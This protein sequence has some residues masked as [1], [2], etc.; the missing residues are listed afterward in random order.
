MATAAQRI[1]GAVTLL[2]VAGVVLAPRMSNN[3]YHS[4]VVAGAL[5]VVILAWT[6]LTGFPVIGRFRGRRVPER[7]WDVAAAVLC[8]SGTGLAGLIAYEGAY[9]VTW[10][11]RM[12]ESSSAVPPADFTENEIQYFSHFPNML[13][14]LAIARTLRSWGS[15]VGVAD[16]DAMFGVLNS[17]GL[18]VTALALYLTIRMARGPAWG[19]LGLLLLFALLGT[20]PWLAVPYTDMLALWTPI[21]AVALF[22][23][24]LR[25]GRWR[26]L[27]L[28][29]AGGAV[30]GVGTTVKATP[31]VGLV[32][33]LLT[34]AVVAISRGGLPS[35]SRRWLAAGALVAVAGFVATTAVAFSW[36]QQN[37]GTPSLP[38]D[39]GATP[40]TYV[41]SGV[42]V[43]YDNPVGITYGG[44]DAVVWHR[45]QYRDKATQNRVSLELIQQEWDA[46][47]PAGMA[48][49]AVEKTLFNW[50][51][52]MFWAWGEGTDADQAPL[53]RGPLAEAV[54]GW[55]RPDGDNFTLRVIA[56][57]VTW[58]AVLSAMGV[59][60][61]LSRRRPEI[62]LAALTV[63]G[64]A[65]FT[66]VFQGRSRYLIGH[67]PVI[68]T[69]SACLVPAPRRSREPA[70][71][72]PGDSSARPETAGGFATARG[73]SIS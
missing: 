9:G 34:L 73:S 66:L 29:A 51:D 71:E 38:A 37:A 55:N 6:L 13:P 22:T 44:Y 3:R 26:H 28:L 54:G 14:L 52:G 50:G 15:P 63:V 72:P 4:G 33:L 67:V 62:L 30:L 2:V 69:L 20:S 27:V 68:V 43:Q 10:D 35:P 12:V 25:R 8:L 46:Q 53:R 48:G 23:F 16:Y 42:R 56:A 45:T 18:L 40:L 19:V 39:R 41:A 49:F 64:I 61:L 65:V 70:V 24:A 32:A 36:V 11:P 60:L 7:V 1:V 17:G 57:Q 47:G 31:S 58:L 21:T 59:G 5:A